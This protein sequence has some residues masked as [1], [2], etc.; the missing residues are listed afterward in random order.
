MSDG[1]FYVHD[2]AVVDEPA[3][4]GS[5]TRVWHFCH[6]MSGAQIGRDCVLGQNVF[7]ADGAVIG[8]RV[9][10][11]NNVSVYRGNVI[12][13]DVFLGPSCVLTNVGTPRSAVER[14]DAFESTRLRQGATIGANATIVCGV[15]VGRFAF[16]AAGAVVTKDVPDFRLV[17]GV[18][19]R[20]VGYMCRCG[21]RLDNAGE[22]GAVRCDACGACYRCEDETI[23]EEPDV[24]RLGVD[25]E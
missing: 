1:D 8:D 15:K 11:Q 23:L 19:A 14:K 25:V 13:D 16:V 2:T 5:G 20:P 12:E 21:V 17:Q 4:I 3:D 10:I 18:P 24:G 7:I 9:K 6:I 22:L